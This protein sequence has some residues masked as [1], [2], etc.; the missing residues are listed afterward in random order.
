M[1]LGVPRET[2]G[3]VKINKDDIRLITQHSNMDHTSTF[4][5]HA[6]NR[7][8]SLEKEKI[9]GFIL[10]KGSP[11]CGLK[12]VPLFSPSGAQTG[13]GEGMFV[14]LLLNYFPLLP[15][16]EAEQLTNPRQCDSFA[17]KV[18][19]YYNHINL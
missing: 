18:L 1:G 11:S 17:A 9:H 12:E 5:T 2:M 7:M 6:K 15:M 4:Q 8:A 16:E 3:L 13:T 19:A 14:S 10:K